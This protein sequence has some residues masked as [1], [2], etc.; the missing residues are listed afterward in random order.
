[1]LCLWH[2]WSSPPTFPF[3]FVIF[4]LLATSGNAQFCFPPIFIKQRQNAK[5]VQTVVQTNPCTE[6]RA[7]QQ[8]K[9]SRWW[10]KRPLG[11]CD[12]P[13]DQR[14]RGADMGGHIGG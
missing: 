2:T 11:T 8:E 3:Y 9:W 6:T 5:N 14:V 1:M 10:E 12:A 7:E 4:V 13:S